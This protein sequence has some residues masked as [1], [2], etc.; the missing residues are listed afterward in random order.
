MTGIPLFVFEEHHE[1]FFVWHYAAK[2]Q[3]INRYNN[4][5]LH[6]DEHSDMKIACLTKSLNC[7]GDSLPEIYRFTYE[8]LSIAD[9][10]IPAIYQGF[11][12][13]IYWLYQ[14]NH[15]G[16]AKARELFVFSHEGE[17]KIFQIAPKVDS[18]L[19]GHKTIFQALKTRENLPE[20]KEVILDI[21]LDYFSCNS[22][23]YYYKGKVEITS[24]E[25]NS[26][27][28]DKHHFL[29]LNLGSAVQAQHREG[30]Y[31]LVFN[32]FN[33]D[34][35]ENPLKA[36]QQQICQRID[37]LVEFLKANKIQPN[38]IDI[39]RSRF[40]GFTPEDQCDFIE[41]N[42]IERLQNLYSLKLQY[43]QDIY[44]ENS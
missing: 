19:D 12:Q 37:G 4:T 22:P 10:M 38:M 3:I 31:Y 29:R 24:E 40:S 5:L 39:C 20:C 7:L 21:D 13:N 1:A 25:Y 32:P 30:K 17:G 41:L 27:R 15:E 8:Q 6:V 36:S 34:G 9:F 26:F 16:K 23:F 18:H 35:L 14:S 28:R 44:R 11:F 2:N 43:I 33:P 42:L